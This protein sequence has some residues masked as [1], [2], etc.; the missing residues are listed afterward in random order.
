MA[1]V[2]WDERDEKRRRAGQSAE[3]G[4]RIILGVSDFGHLL[5]SRSCFDQGLTRGFEHT[6]YFRV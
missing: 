5:V 4:E 1:H 6:Q 2:P 3:E